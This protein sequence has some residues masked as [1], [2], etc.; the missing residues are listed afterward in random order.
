M[1]YFSSEV[2][3]ARHSR[4][5]RDLYMTAEKVRGFGRAS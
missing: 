2:E 3:L 1:G 5:G 4:K